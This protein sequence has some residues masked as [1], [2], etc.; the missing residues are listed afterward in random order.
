MGKLN[1]STTTQAFVI[2]HLKAAG[3]HHVPGKD[4]GREH[5]DVLLED[6]VIDAIE[7]LNPGVDDHPEQAQVLLNE[8]RALTLAAGQD[9]LVE[10]NQRF[11]T[12]L[13]GLHT[14]D[15]RGQNRNEPVHLIDF[16]NP[17]RN[18]YIVS[19]EVTFGAGSIKSRFDIVL[20]VNGIPVVV[21]ETKSSTSASISWFHAAKDIHEHYEPHHPAFF[22]PNILNFA[23]E[24]KDL[25]YAGGRTPL[26]HWQSWDVSTAPAGEYGW[27]RVGRA[28]DTLLTPA[29]I[30]D[31][32]AGFTVYETTRTPAGAPVLIKVLARYPQYE[33]VKLILDRVRD[34]SRNRGLIHHTQGS[35][36]TLAMTF[37]AA[38]MMRDKSLKNPT[39]ILIADRI[40]LVD[41]TY[42]QFRSA[43]MPAL[44][45]PATAE[46]LRTLL[47]S[48]KRGL[49]FTT[50]HKFRDAPVLSERDNIVVLIDEAH[51][52]QEG[53]LGQSL[54]AALP[55]AT[56]FGLTGTPI[57]D[58]EKNTYDLFGHPDDPGRT[59]HAYTSDRSIADG[60]TVPIHVTAR[61][62]DFQLDQEGLDAAFA[63]MLDEEDL[64]DEQRDFITRKAS[65]TSTFFSNPERIE[66]VC[67][68]IVD[69]FYA[70][71]DPL[72]M[73]AQVVVNDRDL[74][75]AYETEL[76]RLLV[77]RATDTGTAPDE[78]RVVMSVQPKDDATLQPYKLTREEENALL[79]RFR[80]YGD[81]LKFLVVTAK[82]GT[83]FD[84]PIEGVLY[85][86]KPLK[87]HTLFQTI[88]RT[89]RNWTHPVTGQ[90]KKNGL[91]VDYVG[92]GEGYARAMVPADPEKAKRHIDLEGLIDVFEAELPSVLDQFN[93]IDRTKVGYE[94]LQAA[95]ERMPDEAARDRFATR[96]GLLEGIWETAW[97]HPRLGP[98]R[99]D[100]GFLAKVYQ[101]IK[102][103][104]SNLDLLWHRLGAKTLDLVHSRIG[105][106]T[107]TATTKEAVVADA[108]TIQ[109]LLDDPTFAHLET[110]VQDKSAQQVLDSI[111][112]RLQARIDGDTGDHKVWATL[113][114]R[115]EALR[116]RAIGQAENA[117]DWLR[118]LL[119]TARDL[120]VAE[121]AE[122][123]G[124]REGLDALPPLTDPNVGALTQIFQEYAPAD[125][126][127]LIGR[128][129]E[130]V[131]SI[132]R[133]V[134]HP[135]WVAKDASVRDVRLALRKTLKQNG[136]SHDGDLFD[137]A[138]GYIE[139]HY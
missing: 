121:H 25:R 91:V 125:T 120:T 31:F 51:R 58:L 82:L 16:R 79:D 60:M 94:V 84:A 124:G 111:T 57:A 86:D 20:W 40:Q 54:R 17:G 137:R 66:T 112:K 122:D 27:D 99:E 30:L 97:P 89:N 41:Q 138:Y 128:I 81:P 74:C 103:S 77:K 119:T 136:L 24:G 87:L 73:K 95:N 114:E 135:G 123:D 14:H 10:T 105:P 45:T 62:V 36:K 56:F 110:E 83:G 19:D 38:Q 33:A 96:F 39:V 43:G 2:D 104:S 133:E 129:V 115:L 100:Y 88:T 8:L 3:W 118:D 61:L 42:A 132:A 130:Q 12:W 18:T 63:E 127:V 13:R 113:A 75:V 21:G 48:D 29:T 6:G 70:T 117:L 106:V 93:G 47:A 80:A 90:R 67:A 85:L 52:T 134:C 9:G 108:G 98:H 64:D 4:L 50:V 11:T 53:G 69:H 7:R 59:L 26:D 71:V 46:A 102:P 116:E 139:Q 72:G 65:R 92:L 109:T 78:V 37:A 55:N 49:I 76:R 131:D 32:L 23:T 28:V 126:P 1:E 34:G 44:S 22:A 35:G 15:F 101:N 107:L 68:D 5:E